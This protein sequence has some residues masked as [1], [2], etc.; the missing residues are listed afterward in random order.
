MTGKKILLIVGAA[1]VAATA[2]AA[3]LTL[4]KIKR[5]LQTVF[6]LPTSI[7]IMSARLLRVRFPVL[8]YNY[9]DIDL[10]I[11]NFRIVINVLDANGERVLFALSP[12]AI[13]KVVPVKNKATAVDIELD[14]D[15][16]A[17]S[18]DGKKPVKID[19]MFTWRFIPVTV[20]IDKTLNDILPLTALNFILGWLKR[21]GIDITIPGLG[22]P[23]TAHDTTSYPN[24]KQLSKGQ[25]PT[26]F[27][28]NIA[29]VL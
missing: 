4:S 8:I 15:P 5:G 7:K 10:T 21:I 25:Y 3:A 2:T 23:Y 11:T 22:N 27:N 12:Q 17:L 9:T 1:A 24:T 28:Q 6:N 18:L 13:E 19:L 16:F 26:L 20:T 29:E 14:I